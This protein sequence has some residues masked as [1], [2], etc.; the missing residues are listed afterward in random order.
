MR[1]RS[2]RVS[3]LTSRNTELYEAS[4]HL[5]RLARPLRLLAPRAGRGSCLLLRPPHLWHPV[6]AV[7]QVV[8]GG[9]PTPQMWF[10]LCWGI[11][12]GSA[13]VQVPRVG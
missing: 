4:Q 7:Q 13:P 10:S 1:T 2:E 5:S 11:T 12:V 9:R 3:A 6:P 8:T